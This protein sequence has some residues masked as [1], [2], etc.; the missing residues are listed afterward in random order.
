MVAALERGRS[1]QR[2]IL[3]GENVTIRRLAELT[4]EILSLKK[5]ILT[6]PTPVVEAIAWGGRTL[7]IPLPFNPNM[8]PYATLYWFTENSKAERELGVRFRN[9]VSTLKPTLEWCQNVGHI[10]KSRATA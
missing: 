6:F 2:Y 9:V 7:R 3:A 4:N 8:I 1:G 10:P 5:T